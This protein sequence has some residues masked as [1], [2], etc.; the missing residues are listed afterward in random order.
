MM[1]YVSEFQL[2]PGMQE[3]YKRR[4]DEIWPEMLELIAVAG[5]RNYSIWNHETLLIE[6]FETDDLTQA[7]CILAASSVKA[8]WDQAMSDILVFRS[9]GAMTPLTLMFQWN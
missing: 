9:D 7:Q 4:H 3:E 1:K 6:Y 8:R 5:L 2:R